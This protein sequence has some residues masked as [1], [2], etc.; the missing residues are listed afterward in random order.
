MYIP[1][2][3]ANSLGA[4]IVTSTELNEMVSP[5]CVITYHYLSFSGFEVWQ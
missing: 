4:L 5:T 2:L 1:L 3:T